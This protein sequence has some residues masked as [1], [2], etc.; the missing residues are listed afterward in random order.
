MTTLKVVSSIECTRG[1]TYCY[2]VRFGQVGAP[3]F[4]PGPAQLR[5]LDRL[6]AGQPPDEVEIIG[7]EPLASEA[8]P[9]T[10][11]VLDRCARSRPRPRLVMSSAVTALTP[12]TAVV[13]YLDHAYLSL[14]PSPSPTNRK[15]VTAALAG[16]THFLT[17]HHVTLTVTAV[18]DGTESAADLD[19]FLAALAAAGVRDAGF[20]IETGAVHPP[21]VLG[22]MAGAIVHLFGRRLE[23]GPIR[24]AGDLLD[25]VEQYFSGAVRPDYCICAESGALL[26]PSGRLTSGTCVDYRPGVRAEHA[27]E[28]AEFAA[29]KARRREVLASTTP[30]RGCPAWSVCGGG[31]TWEAQRQSGDFLTHDREHCAV[32]LAALRR[33]EAGLPPQ[34]RRLS[35]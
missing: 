29:L 13:G 28:P 7:G 16:V 24:P 27:S 4:H 3:E 23:A 1:C 2:N 9:A 6:L 14:D 20:A 10:L 22:R 33:L 11:D 26:E 19:A 17:A 8:L 12:W 31:C 34:Q 32:L 18:L 15:P 30:C 21:A 25:A 35:G 5:S